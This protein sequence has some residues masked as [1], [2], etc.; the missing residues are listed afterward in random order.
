MRIF[1][2][3][4]DR[5]A[6]RRR[7]RSRLRRSCCQPARASASTFAS[8]SGDSAH[9]RQDPEHRPPRGALAGPGKH[10]GRR[11]QGAGNRRRP[12]GAGRR[13]DVGWR[14]VHRPRRHAGA[15]IER[16][17]RSSPTGSRGHNHLFTLDEVQKLDFG[18]WFVATGS[19]QADRGREGDAGGAGRAIAARRRRPCARRWPSPK[20]T[21]GASTSRSRT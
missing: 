1:C 14:A 12:V 10:V 8:T 3:S 6:R 20:T 11:A 2:C 18:S 17:G 15:H 5:R 16:Q 13:H 7:L 19:V 4:A 21:T 9:V